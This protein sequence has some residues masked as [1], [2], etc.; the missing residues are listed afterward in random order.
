MSACFGRFEQ[1]HETTRHNVFVEG[2]FFFTIW[3]TKMS[4]SFQRFEQHHE[5]SWHNVFVDF[6]L[7]TSWT[8]LASCFKTIS[9]IIPCN[10]S[11]GK[12]WP[13]WVVTFGWS[14]P[15]GSQFLGSTKFVVGKDSV[16]QGIIHKT[17]TQKYNE[18]HAFI[19]TRTHACIH[20]YIH[21]YIHTYMQAYMHVC[22]YVCMYARYLLAYIDT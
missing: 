18:I 2:R 19:H 13:F 1:H 4:T 6:F 17:W 12:V 16:G 21:R 9:N 20:A 11:P 7:M 8:N 5:T 3:C 15:K 22:M 10:F 14:G